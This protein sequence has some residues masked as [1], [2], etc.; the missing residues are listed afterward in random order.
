VYEELG[1]QRLLINVHALRDRNITTAM[2]RFANDVVAKHGKKH[3]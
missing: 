3:H 2:E 1:V